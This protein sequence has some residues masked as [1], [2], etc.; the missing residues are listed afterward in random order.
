MRCR[1]SSVELL[2][3]LLS[4]AWST[5]RSWELCRPTQ[6]RAGISSLAAGLLLSS[7][8]EA[9][10]KAGRPT[11]GRSRHDWSF[12]GKAGR[13]PALWSLHARS[14]RKA[15]LPETGAL[16]GREQ[17]LARFLRLL[18][19]ET[20]VRGRSCCRL[21]GAGVLSGGQRQEG[22]ARGP[23]PKHAAQAQRADPYGFGHWEQSRPI[24][25]ELEDVGR[26]LCPPVERPGRCGLRAVGRAVTVGAR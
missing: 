18:G 23:V 16:R 12:V 21:P 2:Q 15:E 26:L 11:L 7:A 14:D 17:V 22:R 8:A 1:A 10:E 6:R 24:R 25:P 19:P 3:A 4:V 5:R 13:S 20:S 9:K